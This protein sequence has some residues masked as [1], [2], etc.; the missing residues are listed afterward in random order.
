MQRRAFIIGVLTLCVSGGA[1]VK[2]VAAAKPSALTNVVQNVKIINN[3]LYA[4]I[5]GQNYLITPSATPN[6]NGGCPI[7]HLALGPIDLSLLGLNVDTSAICLDV[8]AQQGGGVLGNLL[9]SVANLLNQGVP[10]N[11]I[12]GQLNTR[13]QNL[14]TD[15]LKSILNGAL[16]NLFNNQPAQNAAPACNVLSLQLG[17][18][19]LTLLGLQVDLDD[20]ANGPVT[21][22]ITATPGGGL[23]GDLLC[24]LSGGL[25][26]GLTLQQVL[27]LL[28]QLLAPV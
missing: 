13:Q 28:T 21:V 19:S 17:P 5:Q 8:T 14:L 18:L 7:L 10:I 26:N 22:D 2:P 25:F 3:Q 11:Q 6:P 20:C 27:N 9:C 4:T 23:L 12:I 15:A 16:N 1:V 24:G